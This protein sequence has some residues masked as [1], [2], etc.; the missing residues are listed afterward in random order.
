MFINNVDDFYSH[1]WCMFM[2]SHMWCISFVDS[3]IWGMLF[4]DSHAY[5]DDIVYVVINILYVISI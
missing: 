1:I 3:H 2:D 5:V 4:V